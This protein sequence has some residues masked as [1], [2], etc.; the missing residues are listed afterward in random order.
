MY[1]GKGAEP[2]KGCLVS[3]SFLTISQNCRYAAIE[4]QIVHV[5]KRSGLK[6]NYIT[7]KI[8]AKNS[9]SNQIEFL[10]FIYCI[11]AIEPCASVLF[12]INTRIM[13]QSEQRLGLSP[14]IPCNLS[15]CFCLSFVLHSRPVVNRIPFI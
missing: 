14:Q 8:S 5:G 10:P 4:I 9:H 13:P 15:A 12:H 7:K 2:K 11:G 6:S 3:P 1:R